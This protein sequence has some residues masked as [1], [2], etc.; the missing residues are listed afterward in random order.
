M[1]PGGRSTALPVGPG[2]CASRW[3]QAGGNVSQPDVHPYIWCLATRARL[4]VDLSPRA[5][6]VCAQAQ[7]WPDMPAMLLPS[8]SSNVLLSSLFF[9]FFLSYVSPRDPAAFLPPS[10][11][12]VPRCSTVHIH[13]IRTRRGLALDKGSARHEWGNFAG[14]LTGSTR[15]L[16]LRGPWSDGQVQVQVAQWGGATYR[17]QLS[18]AYHPASRCDSPPLSTVACVKV[19]VPQ[20]ALALPPSSA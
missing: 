8:A 17:Y 6:G 18:W 14:D 9:F 16:L 2:A 3:L 10:A 13:T 4:Q 11:V 1:E 20:Q 12:G 15:R 19:P 7:M 5:G